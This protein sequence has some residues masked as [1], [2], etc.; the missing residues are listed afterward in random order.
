MYP[1]DIILLG[2]V[3][4]FF[5][6]VGA[7]TL[8]TLYN[9]YSLPVTLLMKDL[10]NL[11]MT[12]T[13]RIMFLGIFSS[14]FR[15]HLICLPL[16]FSEKLWKTVPKPIVDLINNSQVYCGRT[17]W[18]WCFRYRCCPL[19]RSSLA[20]SYA[21]PFSLCPSSWPVSSATSFPASWL[22]FSVISCNFLFS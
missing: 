21:I 18:D 4:S 10:C 2:G 17:S 15:G 8:Y 5:C 3:K 19:A 13:D 11:R 7:Q 22:S 9:N 14:L 12:L 16:P 1:C 6:I 20:P